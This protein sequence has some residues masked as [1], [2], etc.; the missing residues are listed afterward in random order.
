MAFGSP[1]PPLVARDETEEGN[2]PREW[3]SPAIGHNRRT[4]A[5]LFC[6]A[7]ERRRKGHVTAFAFSVSLRCKKSPRG[8]IRFYSNT[9]LAV[10]YGNSF[11]LGLVM[12]TTTVY[13]TTFCVYCS[14][15]SVR[16]GEA[17]RP[18]LL[19]RLQSGLLAQA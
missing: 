5:E 4:E 12:V 3:P 13:V 2:S 9:T 18:A 14:H 11:S 1:L 8:R 7:K 19:T 15:L 6:N 17:G 10:M 16:N